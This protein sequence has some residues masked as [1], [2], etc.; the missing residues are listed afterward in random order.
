[1]GVR[2]CPASRSPRTEG[3]CFPMP[4]GQPSPQEPC[5][6]RHIPGLHR[7]YSAPSSNVR[8]HLRDVLA[9]CAGNGELHFLMAAVS[10]QT[11]KELARKNFRGRFGPPFSAGLGKAKRENRRAQ[12]GAFKMPRNSLWRNALP[13]LCSS[14][15]HQPPQC[16]A[17]AAV[18]AACGRA[19]QPLE[20]KAPTRSK[21]WKRGAPIRPLD[22]TSAALSKLWNQRQGF[23]P[24]LRTSRKVSFKPRKLRTECDGVRRGACPLVTVLVVPT[25]HPQVGEAYSVGADS[26]STTLFRIISPTLRSVATSIARNRP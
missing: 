1:M 15:W 21:P 18:R 13:A 26:D 19:V 2:R 25:S 8:P 9:G 10:F 22:A 3:T 6:R 12:H 23:R 17:P 16:L 20:A 5:P 24:N 11:I 7:R 4:V 14:V